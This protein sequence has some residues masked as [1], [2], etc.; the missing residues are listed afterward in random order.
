MTQQ[1]PLIAV[2]NS[3]EEVADMLEQLLQ[4]DGYRTVRGYTVD[5]KRDRASLPALLAQH[6]PRAIVWDIALPY[7]ENWQYLQSLRDAGTFHGR[8]LVV[9][10]T[11]KRVL[12]SLV[13][14]TPTH[15]IIG[16]PF[17]VEELLA[18]VKRAIDGASPA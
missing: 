17:D 14:T 8:G 15:E 7:E 1:Q 10:T 3:S 12:D 9:T 16:K 18:A 4:S 2:A 6:D 11:N 13:G 5:F